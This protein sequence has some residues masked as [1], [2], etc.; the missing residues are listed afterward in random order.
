MS[1][2]GNQGTKGAG[3]V[4][5]LGLSPGAIF[6]CGQGSTDDV[7]SSLSRITGTLYQSPLGENL[8]RKEMERH[9]I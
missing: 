2:L 5:V 1:L 7:I 6:F 4:T 9:N 8:P 3:K